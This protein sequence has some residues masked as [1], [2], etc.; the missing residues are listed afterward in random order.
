[1]RNFSLPISFGF[2]FIGTINKNNNT[3]KSN[4]CMR[5]DEKSEPKISALANDDYLSFF[6]Q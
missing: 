6:P 2:F 4:M 1:M 3:K 5:K